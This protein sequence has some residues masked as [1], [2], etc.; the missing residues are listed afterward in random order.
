[1]SHAE[2]VIPEVWVHFSPV[3]LS[4]SNLADYLEIVRDGCLIAKPAIH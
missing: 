4:K 1:L 3:M 2:N